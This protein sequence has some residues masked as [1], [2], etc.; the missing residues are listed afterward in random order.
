M[1][2][3]GFDSKADYG[4]FW[5]HCHS[6]LSKWAIIKII[7]LGHVLSFPSFYCSYMHFLLNLNVNISRGCE[8]LTAAPSSRCARFKSAHTQSICLLELRST[9]DVS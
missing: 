5:Q 6:L 9:A 2:L 7:S 4:S 8:R 3:E 1:F